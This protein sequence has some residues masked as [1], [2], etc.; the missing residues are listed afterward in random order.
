M[1]L[2]IQY[3]GR[4]SSSA[5]STKPLGPICAAQSVIPINWLVPLRSRALSRLHPEEHRASL[6]RP[7]LAVSVMPG[8]VPGIHVFLPCGEQVVD[9]RNKSGDDDQL[10]TT[11]ISPTRFRAGFTVTVTSCPSAVKNSIKRPTEN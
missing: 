6:T 11:S 7:T 2:W 4:T 5:S 3:S 8:L 10:P 1:N 9:G